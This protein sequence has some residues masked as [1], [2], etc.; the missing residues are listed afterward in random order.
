MNKLL[1]AQDVA[2]RLGVSLGEIYKLAARG[3]I[4]HI[5][6]GRR[7]RFRGDEIE[8]WL[9]GKGRPPTEAGIRSAS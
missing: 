3:E 1:L 5:R 4:P 9:D 6:L 8:A 2:E 7:L